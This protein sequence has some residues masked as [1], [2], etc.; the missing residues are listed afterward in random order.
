MRLSSRQ[1]Q[2]D[3]SFL[4]G[5]DAVRSDAFGISKEAKA[6]RYPI[7]LLRYWFG[8]HLLR[9]EY[10]QARTPFD[11]CE[12]GV[13]SGQMLQFANS[14]KALT[15]DPVSW[16]TWTAV[17]A[18]LKRE[19]LES[20]GYRDLVEANLEAGPLTLGRQYDAVILLHVLEHL[21]DPEAAMREI[22]AIV[23]PGGLVIGG[24]PVLPGFLVKIWQRQ[25][26]KKARPMGHVSVFSPGRVKTMGAQAG[27]Q[28]EFLSGAFFMRSK[29]RW[30]ENYGGWMRF[31]LAFGAMFP[32]WPG[33]I[34]WSMRK[35]AASVDPSGAPR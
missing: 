28:T 17:D 4:D 32:S 35:P 31:N 3:I 6:V 29:G 2:W 12:I 24:F 18:V 10:G 19:Q 15:R 33:E 34:Y 23:R 9:E 22:S 21:F 14:G 1:A 13:D 20:A 27:L 11:V 5:N 16:N 30:M 25:L 26:R 7:R 8:Y